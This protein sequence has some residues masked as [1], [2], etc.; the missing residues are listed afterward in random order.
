MC[1]CS[2]FGRCFGIQHKITTQLRANVSNM[3]LRNFM[4]GHN[5]FAFFIRIHITNQKFFV[6]LPRTARYKNF[7]PLCKGFCYWQYFSHFSDISYTVETRIV[8]HSNTLYAKTIQQLFRLFVLN[9]NHG[10]GIEQM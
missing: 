5:Q 6:W 7:R 10:K 2:L 1:I 8:A 4:G 3:F 9:K